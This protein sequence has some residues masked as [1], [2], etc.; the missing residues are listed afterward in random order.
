MAIAIKNDMKPLS[1]ASCPRDGPTISD[2]MISAEAGSLPA[3]KTLEISLVSFTVKFPVISER[4]P[5][6][7]PEETPGAV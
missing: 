4:P 1:I 6:I 5:E 3:R 2:C 7:G